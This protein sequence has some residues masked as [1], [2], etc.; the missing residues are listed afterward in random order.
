[1]DQERKDELNYEHEFCNSHDYCE[2][3]DKSFKEGEEC[4]KC[5]DQEN[6]DAWFYY[7]FQEEQRRKGNK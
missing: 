5:V 2:K 4:S 1:M 3:H 6:R 7:K